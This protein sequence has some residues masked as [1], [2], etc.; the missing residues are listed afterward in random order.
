MSHFVRYSVVY[1]ILDR[2]LIM[3]KIGQL[4][5]DRSYTDGYPVHLS[6][7]P[8]RRLSVFPERPSPSVVDIWT[9]IIRVITCIKQTQT[10]LRSQGMALS[11]KV[12]HVTGT[13][14][15]CSGT[16]ADG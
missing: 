10:A 6:G 15:T 3:A 16:P 1:S 11:K 13:Y 2:L 14:L 4:I 8:I 12:N 9:T 5:L 7:T